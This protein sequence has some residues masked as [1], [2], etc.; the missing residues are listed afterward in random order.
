ML[1]DELIGYIKRLESIG[2]ELRQI[3]SK[4]NKP[5]LDTR[6]YAQLGRAQDVTFTARAMLKEV[7]GKLLADEAIR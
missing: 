5:G 3:Q 2:N 6:A 4:V 7:L 1:T